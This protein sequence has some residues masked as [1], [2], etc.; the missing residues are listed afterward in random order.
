MLNSFNPFHGIPD[1]LVLIGIPVGA[2]S[3]GIEDPIAVVMTGDAVSGT[4]IQFRPG[5]EGLL[6]E[7]TRIFCS[8]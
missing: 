3:V 4:G 2:L 8:G 6:I 1:I 5:C 7:T